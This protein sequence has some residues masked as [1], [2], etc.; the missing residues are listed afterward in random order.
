MGHNNVIS[1]RRFSS[2]QYNPRN[3][4]SMAAVRA[5]CP[6][7]PFFVYSH[8]RS[9]RADGI[10]PDGYHPGQMFSPVREARVHHLL[11]RLSRWPNA[12]KK[13]KRFHMVN[14]KVKKPHASSRTA[15]C[16]AVGS[17]GEQSSAVYSGTHRAATYIQYLIQLW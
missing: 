3:A 11:R 12:F 9:W 10:P 14:K 4:T 13:P 8:P 5:Q 1:T 17:K 15:G 2:N 6:L 7:N 16:S